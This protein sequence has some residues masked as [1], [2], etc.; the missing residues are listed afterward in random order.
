MF[1]CLVSQ[2]ATYTIEEGISERAGSEALAAQ[3]LGL[4]AFTIGLERMTYHSRSRNSPPLSH[5]RVVTAQLTL[6]GPQRRHSAAP[7]LYFKG[8]DCHRPAHLRAYWIIEGEDGRAGEQ[9][10]HRRAF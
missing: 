5:S 3:F 1:S 6:V 8:H 2:R 10:Y 7:A 9:V 4:R